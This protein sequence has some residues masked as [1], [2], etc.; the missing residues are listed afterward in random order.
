MVLFTN[1]SMLASIFII[2]FPQLLLLLLAKAFLIFL[3][4]VFNPPQM[5]R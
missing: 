2:S 3:N 4:T 5:E 1:L